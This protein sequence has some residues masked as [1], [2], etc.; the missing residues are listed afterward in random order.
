AS[1]RRR[2]DVKSFIGSQGGKRQS[3][4][5]KLTMSRFASLAR[6][7]AVCGGIFMVA[8]FL[9]AAVV[10]EA[11]NE[12]GIVKLK[13]TWTQD[14]DR[15]TINTEANNLQ[16]LG[17]A[18]GQTIFFCVNNVP[19]DDPP[20]GE[21]NVRSGPLDTAKGVPICSATSGLPCV[22]G[23]VNTGDEL[24]AATALDPV[25]GACTGTLITAIFN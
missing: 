24:E 5:S 6:K 2:V 25:T 14:G 8:G 17:A 15:R 22:P 21:K 23:M 1:P 4:R 20:N 12:V 9:L 19:F 16:E 3:K 7:L 10:H 13:S 18:R 11:E